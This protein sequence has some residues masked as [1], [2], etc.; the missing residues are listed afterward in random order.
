MGNTKAKRHIHK[1]ARVNNAYMRVWRCMLPDCSH[2]L[3]N[4][5]EFLLEGKYTMCWKC[6]NT[7]I[8]NPAQMDMDK[9]LCDECLGVPETTS[10][11]PGL[12]ELMKSKGLM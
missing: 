10:I 3:P 9:P 8:M 6:G 7:C 5:Q 11:S 2:Y 12:M 4:H 1:Y